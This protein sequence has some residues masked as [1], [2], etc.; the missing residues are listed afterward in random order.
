MPNGAEWEFNEQQERKL[1][2]NEIEGNQL[3]FREKMNES[4]KWK[5]K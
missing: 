3:E 4:K 1:L 2:A 5:R